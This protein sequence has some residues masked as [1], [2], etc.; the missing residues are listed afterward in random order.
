[1]RLP[2]PSLYAPIDCLPARKDVTQPLPLLAARVPACFLLAALCT[3]LQYPVTLGLAI[4]ILEA[5]QQVTDVGSNIAIVVSPSI[6]S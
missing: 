4:K 6:F 2:R 5:F 3:P 1:L